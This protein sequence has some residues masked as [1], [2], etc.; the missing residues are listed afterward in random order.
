ML[1][2][3]KRLRLTYALYNFF[4]KKQLVHNL[5]V[6]KKY[7][8]RKTYFSPV[9]SRDFAHLANKEGQPGAGAEALHQHPVVQQLSLQ[10]QQSLANFSR[11]GYAILRG[12]FSPERVDA[13]NKA[14]E[15]LLEKKARQHEYT[16]EFQAERLLVE[17]AGAVEIAH[18]DDRGGRAVPQQQ[19]FLE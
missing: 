7:G 8:I 12:F 11:E 17:R 19:L 2:F 6:Y 18:R 13:A 15:Q 3:L 5:P 14:V 10:D 4:H 9:S 16:N 1:G